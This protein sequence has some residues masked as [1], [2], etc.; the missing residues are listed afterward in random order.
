MA[1]VRLWCC[2][3]DTQI[4]KYT[5]DGAKVFF[6]VTVLLCICFAEKAFLLRGYTDTHC[7]MTTSICVSFFSNK[8]S[9]WNFYLAPFG[10]CPNTK[11]PKN[12][13][14][15]AVCRQFGSPRGTTPPLPF[16]LGHKHHL[17]FLGLS[18]NL[19]VIVFFVF[20][21]QMSTFYWVYVG[22]KKSLLIL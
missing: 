11:T 13:Q 7:K 18:S 15:V 3:S 14:N 22:I 17:M 16:C 4:H 2:Y 1:Y 9:T 12:S 6:F 8:P 5:K 19:F 21:C 10:T 20:A